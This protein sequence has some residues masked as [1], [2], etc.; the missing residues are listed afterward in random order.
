MRFKKCCPILLAVWP[1]VYI[2]GAM[3]LSEKIATVFFNVYIIL[4]IVIYI[5]NIIYACSFHEENSYYKLSYWNMVIKLIHIPFYAGIVLVSVFLLI[6]MVVPAFI[7]LTPV[8][9]VILFFVSLFLMLTSSV[10]GI[11]ALIRARRKNRISTKYMILNI[12]LHL[13]FVTDAIS[14][15]VLFM[16]MKKQNTKPYDEMTG[17]DNSKI[18]ENHISGGEEYGRQ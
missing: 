2:L 10:Y 11:N 5:F 8:M 15:I 7:M 6:A 1:Y 12:I 4:T 16:K 3:L 13:L 18:T 17:D 14:S 9:I